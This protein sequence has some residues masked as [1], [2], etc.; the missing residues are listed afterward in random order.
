MSSDRDSLGVAFVV[1]SAIGFGLLGPLAR[2]ASE[3]GFSVVSFAMWRAIASA[4]ALAVLLLV[5]VAAGRLRSTPWAAIPRF[6]RAQLAAMGVFVAGTTLA[7]FSAFERTTIALALMVFYTF[8]VIVAVA[9]VPLYGEHLGRRRIIALALAG[10]GLLLLLAPGRQA[11]QPGLEVT[12]IFF[13]LLAAACQVGYALV[14]GR[15]FRSV[16]D[17]QSA[18]ILRT[19]SMLVYVVILAPLTV[20][21]GAAG[22]LV[23]PVGSAQAWLLILV[24]GVLGAALPTALLVAGYRRVGPSRGAVLMLVEP[25]TGVLLA[26]LVLQ[27]RPATS[28]LAGIVLV[29]VGAALAQRMPGTSVLSSRPAV[30]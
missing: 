3:I 2:W 6:E 13:A 20:V 25:V 11:G 17:M 4:V 24:A 1:L 15:G 22:T 29:L 7:L 18:T 23:E 26:A 12:G 10:L 8:P 28:Q 14:A 16:P 21:A 9:A 27:E 30:E 5:G 19:V